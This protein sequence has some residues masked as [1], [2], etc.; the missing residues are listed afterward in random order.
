MSRNGKKPHDQADYRQRRA[1]LMASVT[2][3]TR[4]GRCGKV[5]SEHPQRHKTGKR[6][7]WHT[8]H[9]LDGDNRGPLRLEWSTC[10][11][12]AGGKLGAARRAERRI[13]PH[14]PMHYNLEDPQSIGAPPC[15][16]VL[17]S[18]CATCAGWHANQ[19]TTRRTS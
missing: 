11:L 4:C 1:L 3:R 15:V 13:E 16:A 6:A 18:L 2:P 12:S 8:G 17:G 14:H 9:V 19:P 10:N 7:G 5:A